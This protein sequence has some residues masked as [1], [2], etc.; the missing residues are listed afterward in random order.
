[1]LLTGFARI[2]AHG[3]WCLVAGLITGVAAPGLAQIMTP[4]I[5]VFV[6]LL[7][8]M[9]AF[10]VGFSDAFGSI[11]TGRAALW[12]MLVLQAL[13]PL[14][15]CVIVL[16]LGQGVPPFLLAVILMLAA[17]PVSGVPNFA[18]MNGHDPAPALRLLVL[19]TAAFPIIALPVFWALPQLGGAEGLDASLRLIVV[20]LGAAVIGFGVRH[21]C[22]TG[23]KQDHIRA[24][25]GA[26]AVALGLIV[27]GLMSAIGPLLRNDP[28][29]LCAWILAVFALNFGLQGAVF[30]IYRGVGRVSVSMLSLIHIS[31]PTRPY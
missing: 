25:D 28:A 5:P 12:Q 2:A 6:A 16:T 11:A 9:A 7:L 19:G 10:R 27:I 8:S 31:E 29:Q 14:G 17:P 24:V 3:R 20:I 22:G 15:L 23:V 13:L 18:I 4:L 30:M 21:W 1:M 26:S